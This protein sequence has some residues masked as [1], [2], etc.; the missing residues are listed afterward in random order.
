MPPNSI[1]GVV[2]NP[3][4][5]PEPAPSMLPAA[6]Y[7]SAEVLAWE[8]RHLYAGSWTCLG[9]LD[10]L[11]ADG[12]TQRGVRVG[13]VPGLLTSEAGVVRLFANTCRHR[14]HE[15]LSDGGSGDR[16]AVVCP[17]HAWIY[18]LGG[19]LLAAPGYRGVAGFDAAEH[20]LVELPSAVWRGW[21]FGHGVHPRGTAE[22][23]PFEEHL[24]ALDDLITAYLM[25]DLRLGER[26]VYEVAANW[27]VIA[28]NYHECYHCPQIHPELCAVS[29]PTSGDNYD[30]PGAWVGGRMDL[31]EGMATMS[32]TGE[33]GGRPI[34]GAPATTVEYVHLLPNLLVS[35]HPDYVMTHRLTPL[36]PGRTR[37]ECSW[38]FLPD[39]EGRLPDPAYAVEFW[40]LTNRQDWAA[41][42][43]VQRGLAS[44]HF[45][46][47]PFAPGEDAVARFAG[48]IARAYDERGCPLS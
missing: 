7:T 44:P 17:Y 13:D 34:P 28:E 6:A 14:G 35:A 11:L 40:D 26:H 27:K 39:D 42:E 24:G 47:G 33:S 3:T 12:T 8:L 41:C 36:R 10:E 22:V 30:L 31:R 19:R 9:R 20:G 2:G 1:H 48:M 15:L 46:P 38:W 45:R 18:D 25:E 21:V 5:R 23:V 16:S 37:I 29:P 4:P 32:L 43:S